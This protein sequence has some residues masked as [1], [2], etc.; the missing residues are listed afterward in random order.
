MSHLSGAALSSSN[1]SSENNGSRNAAESDEGEPALR[2]PP[3]IVLLAFICVLIVVVNGIVIFLAVKKRTLK[4]LTNMFLASLALSDLISGLLGFPLLLLC[5]KSDFIVICVASTIFFRF[6]AISSVCHVLLIALDR[7]V[8]IVHP[9]KHETIVRKWRAISA[10]AFVW[11]FSLAASIVQLSWYSL[12]ESSLYEYDETEDF[13]IKYIK[14]CIVLFFVIPLILMCYIYGRIFYISFKL[15]RR[16]HQL[17]GSLQNESRS[18]LHE[19]R[20]R[21]VLLIMVVIFAGCWLPFFLAMLGDHMESTQL[22]HSPVWVQR[23]LLVLNFTPPLLNPILCT[24]AKKDFRKALSE[25]VFRKKDHQ[26]N[27]KRFYSQRSTATDL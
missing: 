5:L 20:G 12:D 19:W 16:D 6:T 15:A 23:L 11:L 24:L 26:N 1:S 18:V 8:A 2:P 13:D 14:A 3:M 27:Q 21:S 22:S 9:L 17:T 4:S 7:Y 10:T 25:V